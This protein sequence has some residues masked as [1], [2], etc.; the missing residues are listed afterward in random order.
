MT[1][2]GGDRHATGLCAL[3]GALLAAGC[4]ETPG[5]TTDAGPV[6]GGVPLCGTTRALHDEFDDLELVWDGWGTVTSDT[7]DGRRQINGSAGT[8]GGLMTS[9]MFLAEGGEITLALRSL[10]LGPG[11]RFFLQL[12]DDDEDSI[13]LVLEG[14]TLSLRVDVDG[15]ITSPDSARW[16]ED[17]L[18]WR[19]REEGGQLLWSV[20][21]NGQDW[22]EHQP[23][24]NP[25]PGLVGV[26]LGLTGGSVQSVVELDAINPAS[27]ELE[28]QAA[29]L[30]D[31]FDDLSSRWRRTGTAGCEVAAAGDLRIANDETE[32][33]GIHS[34]EHFD[35]RGGAMAIDVVDIG[36][37]DPGVGFALTVGTLSAAMECYEVAG[38]P[39]LRA[40][41]Y[42]VGAP[43]ELVNLD[44]IATMHRL[45]RIGNAGSQ[46]TWS[47]ATVEGGW[48]QLGSTTIDPE[49][50]ATVG[51]DLLVKDETP[52]GAAEEVV[53]DHLNLVP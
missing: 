39:K 22:E 14:T 8:E 43:G 7:A 11:G 36:D 4:L 37:C 45:W 26:V 15:S 28:C 6:D 49:Q 1:C 10:D 21:N 24:D 19:L 17:M 46:L 41:L 3:A 30:V 16:E 18:W 51:L 25:M 42:G 12:L 50:V 5:N 20:S 34:F 32:Y 9:W 35:L 52:D 48:Q 13:A 33:C 47:V 27:T 23:I 29:S 31:E 44:Y 2:A 53:L 40:G 38:Q